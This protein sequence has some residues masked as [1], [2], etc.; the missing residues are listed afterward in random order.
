MINPTSFFKRVPMTEKDISYDVDIEGRKILCVDYH[1]NKVPLA[2][3]SQLFGMCFQ[4]L[5]TGADS[6][7][8]EDII[9]FGND[10]DCTILEYK[11]MVGVLVEF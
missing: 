1:D 10:S 5:M 3:K 8:E 7:V 6:S 2:D 11:D 9:A 4:V